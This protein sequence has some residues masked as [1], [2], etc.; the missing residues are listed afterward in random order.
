MRVI[1]LGGRLRSG[2]DAV[3][4]HLVAKH[5]FAKNGMSDP[6]LEAALV[7]DPYVAWDYD[8]VTPGTLTRLSE[9]VR[10]AGY[11]EAKKNPEVRRFLQ[12]LGTDFGRQMV[13]ENLWV[14]MA[15]KTIYK[16]FREGRS[17]A[18]TGIRYPNEVEMIRQAGGVSVWV[19]RDSQASA[20]HSAHISENGVGPDD[21]DITLS[22]RGTLGDLYSAIDGLVERGWQV[23]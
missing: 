1:G 19:E 2:K 3:A 11:V 13:G 7:L 9:M 10:V 16:H 4:D 12:V 18:I 20:D 17:V 8:H 23:A 6:L 5:G 14:D 21:F 22:N 15:E